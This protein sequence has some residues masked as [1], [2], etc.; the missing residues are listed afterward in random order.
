VGSD[1]DDDKR[2][3]ISQQRKELM[4]A[5]FYKYASSTAEHP[6]VDRHDIEHALG[7]WRCFWVFVEA[8]I[9]FSIAAVISWTLG[10][11]SLEYGFLIVVAVATILAALQRAR[12]PSYARPQIQA[13]AADATAAYAV[14]RRFD[15][16]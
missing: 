15:A 10:S 12:L 2:I 4:R 6:V 11:W 1:V 8:I 16:L 7:A 9:Y 3:K 5:I 14:K 13:I